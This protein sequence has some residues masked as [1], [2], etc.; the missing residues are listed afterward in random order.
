[1]GSSEQAPPESSS[2]PIFLQEVLMSSKLVS[3]STTN[4]HSKRR[5]TSTES[6]EPVDSV[7]R[8]LQSTSSFLT[9]PSSS[10]RSR[11]ITTP[12]SK[13]C[14]KTLRISTQPEA[15]DD[16]RSYDLYVTYNN[17]HYCH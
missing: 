5:T 6:V 2:P 4:Y 14:H 9:T 17:I 3:L 13:R 8:V 7:G 10:E 16:Q 15:S 1:M 12:R 11:I